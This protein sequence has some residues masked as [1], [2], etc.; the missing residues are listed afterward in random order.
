V[1]ENHAQIA[2]C[3]DARIE[4]RVRPFAVL[5]EKAP[6]PVSEKI[7]NL[8]RSLDTAFFWRSF[9]VRCPVAASD[10]RLL[11]QAVGELEQ[12][13]T[14]HASVG[15]ISPNAATFASTSLTDEEER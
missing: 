5:A 7:D 11:L 3:L 12:E 2:R 9:L 1:S 6:F 13:L 4:R 8:H 10:L 15:R 14:R